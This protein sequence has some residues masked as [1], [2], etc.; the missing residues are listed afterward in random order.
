MLE[1]ATMFNIIEWVAA[2]MILLAVVFMARIAKVT[3]WFKA[4]SILSAAFVLIFVR[5]VV[6][7]YAPLSNF[8]VELGYLNS[9]ISFVLSAL[10]IVGFRMLYTIFKRQA[11]QKEA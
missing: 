5:R 10:Y 11:K 7:A 9:I 4:W 6:V 3:G 1:I 8:K 2:A